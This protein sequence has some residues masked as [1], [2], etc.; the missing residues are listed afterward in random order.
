M[1]TVW[2]EMDWGDGTGGRSAALG[3]HEQLLLLQ[4]TE[5]CLPQFL[6][7]VCSIGI[8]L[9]EERHVLVHSLGSQRQRA[10]YLAH[11]GVGG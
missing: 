4:D 11:S 9:K 1:G 7:T 5:N 8:K 6:Y 2:E 10:L 3:T